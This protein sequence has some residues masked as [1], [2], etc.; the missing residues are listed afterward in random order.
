[1]NRFIR[2]FR[3]LWMVLACLAL[4]FSQTSFPVQA[5]LLA[6]VKASCQSKSGAAFYVRSGPGMQYKI[7]G[8]I[9]G[10]TIVEASARDQAGKWLYI[11]TEELTGWSAAALLACDIDITKL[12]VDPNAG[13]PDTGNSNKVTLRK[14]RA[15]DGG[16]N[17]P[18]FVAQLYTMPYTEV[19]TVGSLQGVPV[20]HDRLAFRVSVYDSTVGNKDGDGIQFLQFNFRSYVLDDQGAPILSDQPD[21]SYPQ[22]EAPSYCAFGSNDVNCNPPLRLDDSWPDGLYEM[23]IQMQ[24]TEDDPNNGGQKFTNWNQYFFFV[25]RSTQPVKP[26]P[27]PVANL[28]QIGPESTDSVVSDALVF[29]VEAYNPAVGNQDG[30]GIDRVDMEI[31]GPNGRRVYQNTESN[32]HYCAFQGG[33]PDCNIWRFADHNYRWPK[34]GPKI[35]NGATYTLHAVVRAK[36]GKWVELRQQI[37]IEY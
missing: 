32:A 1:M 19:K 35:Q 27:K 33:E 14:S 34:N 24:G 30:D 2:P 23:T 21:H 9:T 37:Q 28:V 11:A 36:N 7:L 3:S 26:Q 15:P 18:D 13:T 8:K 29:Q 4:L 5:R 22:D 10:Q 20:F 31:L 16:V 17:N 12:P 6:P 25:Q